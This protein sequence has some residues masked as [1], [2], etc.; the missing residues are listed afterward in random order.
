M[1]RSDT[2]AIF[3]AL[4]L[5]AFLIAAALSVSSAPIQGP[6][7][8]DALVQCGRLG[9]GANSAF[10]D[11][12]DFFALVKRVLDFIWNPLA[13]SVAAGMMVY[14]GFLMII[15]SLGAGSVGMYER[16]KHTLWNVLIGFVIVFFSWIILDTIIKVIVGGQNNLASTVPG[17]LFPGP[18]GQPLGP[19][20]KIECARAP[21]RQALA[22]LEIPEEFKPGHPPIA[23]FDLSDPLVQQAMQTTS[24]VKNSGARRCNAGT[25]KNL[26]NSYGSTITRIAGEER[27]DPKLLASIL[28]IESNG[29]NIT[30]IGPAGEVG[31]AQTLITSAKGVMGW[32]NL[33]PAEIAQRL[34]TVETSIRAGARILRAGVTDRRTNGNMRYGIATYNAGAGALLPSNDCLRTIKIACPKNAGKLPMAL[35]YADRVNE[36]YTMMG[37]ASLF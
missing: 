18:G 9:S 17:G 36:C 21:E 20:N 22:L 23:G 33:S 13:V 1:M 7:A 28:L 35:D 27:V 16:G 29:T 32:D 15:P 37:G 4:F 30:S 5:A 31:M 6:P 3:I 8:D 11:V 2:R 14:A 10:C 25:I 34:R 24:T 12:C 26:N 19:W